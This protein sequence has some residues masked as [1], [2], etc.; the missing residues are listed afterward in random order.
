M[1]QSTGEPSGIKMTT[2]KQMTLADAIKFFEDKGLIVHYEGDFK[3]A[4]EIL[5]ANGYRI[6]NP[7]AYAAHLALVAKNG[8]K[9]W[10]HDH[11]KSTV[12]G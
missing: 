7:V 6:F 2:D 9:E 3:Q 1:T 5:H 10:S 11:T 4:T 12:P 8:G